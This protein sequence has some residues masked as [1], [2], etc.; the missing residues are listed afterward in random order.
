MRIDH[1]DRWEPETEHGWCSS[2]GKECTII[3]VDDGIG[4]YEF[5]GQKGRDVQIIAVSDCCEES[6]LDIDPAT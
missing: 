1:D 3:G 4:P 2:C 5:W 6:V